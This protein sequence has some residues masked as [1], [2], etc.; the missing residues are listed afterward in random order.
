MGLGCAY[1]SVRE[2]D[3][4]QRNTRPLFD[5]HIECSTETVERGIVTK[6]MMIQHCH[7]N[8]EDGDKRGTL[9]IQSFVSSSTV[10]IE[11]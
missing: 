6:E 7:Q 2:S 3:K 1:N 9:K 10:R 5:T 4:K 8:H 11:R